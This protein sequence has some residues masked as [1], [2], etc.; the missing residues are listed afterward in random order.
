MRPADILRLALSILRE[1]RLR[2]ALTIIGIA[3]G[4]AAMVT[5]MGTVEGYSNVIVNKLSTLGQ[6]TIV[7]LPG[8]DYTLTDHDVERLRMIRGVEDVAPF[9]M[10]PAVFRRRDG[11]LLEVTLYATDI[12]MVFKLIGTLRFLE[13]GVP[14]SR[15]YTSG[16]VGYK[17]AFSDEGE[18]LLRVGQAVTVRVPVVVNGR[19]VNKVR[20]IRVYGILEEYGSAFTVN[21]DTTIFLPLEAG[22]FLLG[23]SR[24]SGVLVYVEDPAV[25]DRVVDEIKD[26]YHDLVRVIAFQQVA[27]A[28]S[29]VIRALDFLLFALSVSAF[30]VAVTGI[31]ATMFTSVMERTREIGVLKAVGFSSRSVLVLILAETLV[32]SMIGG[33]V[34][35]GLGVAGAYALSSRSF[36][37]AGRHEIVIM[38]TPAITPQLIAEAMGLAI[39][40]GV[41]GGLIPAYMASRVP[42]VVALRYE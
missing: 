5:I 19:V 37:I 30:A 8:S 36:R 42:P 10:K 6:N 13:G 32:M 1:R 21:P 34:G 31:M 14:P 26:R 15:A 28:V 3:I 35:V 11:S 20:S 38:A 22:R 40:V 41:I 4:P 2:A 33:A 23:M 25:V 17:L 39:F 27:R 9:Y 29:S 18:K 7:V 12:D 24:Y 16:I